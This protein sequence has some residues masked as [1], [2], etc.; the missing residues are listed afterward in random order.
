MTD[1]DAIIEDLEE[2]LGDLREAIESTPTFVVQSGDTVVNFQPYTIQNPPGN[3]DYVYLPNLTS[4]GASSKR[5]RYLA[6]LDSHM[7]SLKGGYLFASE[8]EAKAAAQVMID[9]FRAGAQ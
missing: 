6:A 9:I 4:R 8:D 5:F 1:V 2:G 3:Y 7:E